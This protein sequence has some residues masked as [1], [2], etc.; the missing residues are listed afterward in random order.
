MIQLDNKNIFLLDGHHRHQALVELYNAGDLDHSLEIIVHCYRSDK[1][2]SN[3]T[4][5]LFHNLNH[6]K[7]YSI[8]P[9][10]LETTILVIDFLEK[11]YP[12]IIKDTPVRT[13][14]PFIHKKTLNEL[15]HRRLDSLEEFSYDS[16]INNIPDINRYYEIN[17]QR[18][19]ESKK[20]CWEKVKPKLEK[21]GCYLGIAP[22]E[23]WVVEITQDMDNR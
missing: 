18:M 7:P 15:L 23:K 1:I 11:T 4:V 5:K 3:R 8:A 22:L 10:V 16:I 9:P 19:V 14:F 6:T 12:G 21:T 2:N 17:A 13:K 20:K